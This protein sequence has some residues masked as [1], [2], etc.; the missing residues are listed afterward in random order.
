[1]WTLNCCGVAYR[2]N[3]VWNA[4]ALLHLL[5]YSPPL[6]LSLSLSLSL[7]LLLLLPPLPHI[8]HRCRKQTTIHEIGIP[9][10]SCNV[11]VERIQLVY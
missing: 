3:I 1:M 5:L 6:H 9:D 11:R 2:T 4:S 10:P 8:L 7:P